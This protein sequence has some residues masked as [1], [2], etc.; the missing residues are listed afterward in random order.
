[1]TKKMK[2]N[3]KNRAKTWIE[4]AMNIFK[5]EVGT[6]S[7]RIHCQRNKEDNRWSAYEEVVKRKEL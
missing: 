3:H 5:N 6:Q 1:M 7:W 4:G 2:K